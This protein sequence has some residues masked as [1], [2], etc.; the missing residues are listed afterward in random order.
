MFKPLQIDI[1]RLKFECCTKHGL[2][3]DEM[4]KKIWPILLNIDVII[5]EQEELEFAAIHTTRSSE[6]L[7]T[8]KLTFNNKSDN[9][10]KSNTQTFE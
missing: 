6:S 9:N 4:R 1:E 5:K 2:V 3:N 7:N 10:F 8:Q